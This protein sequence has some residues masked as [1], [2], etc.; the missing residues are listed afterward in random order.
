ME[1]KRGGVA[2]EIP[3]FPPLFPDQ[4]ASYYEQASVAAKKHHDTRRHLFLNFLRE[5]FNV[6]PVEIELERRVK[7][8]ELRGRIDALFRHIIIEVKTFKGGPPKRSDLR[9]LMD[10]VYF[11]RQLN[12]R[13]LAEPDFF[14]WALDTPIEEDFLT[15]INDLFSH[16]FAFDFSRL[17]EDV[18]KSLY[19]ELIDPE[20]RHDLGEYY[21][22]DW[23]AEL[24]LDVYDTRAGDFWIQPADQA[25]FSLLPSMRSAAEVSRERS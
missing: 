20:T 21:T 16:F 2:R 12:L 5:S 4:L 7:V 23:L 18:L 1:V 10:G 6:D 11:A 22:P 19:Q 14:S 17:S 15:L 9:G 8:G 25:R 3:P 13:N 24:T